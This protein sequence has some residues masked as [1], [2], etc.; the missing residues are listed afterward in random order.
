ME[1]HDSLAQ[2][3]DAQSGLRRKHGWS[4][5]LEPI[6][7]RYDGFTEQ[8]VSPILVLQNMGYRWRV[9]HAIGGVTPEPNLSPKR[10]E[11]IG[12]WLH[13]PDTNPRLVVPRS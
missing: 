5:A 7:S 13:P 9:E 10:N 4:E 11:P 8:E 12:T 3:T 2:I 6:A 1:I